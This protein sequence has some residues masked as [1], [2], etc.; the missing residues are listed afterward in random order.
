MLH[1]SQAARQTAEGIATVKLAAQDIAS[2]RDAR[3]AGT[4]AFTLWRNAEKGAAV[5]AIARIL[6]RH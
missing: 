4:K 6:V 5:L 2:S 3:E 1:S